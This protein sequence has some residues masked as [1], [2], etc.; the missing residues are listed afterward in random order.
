MDTWGIGICVSASQKGLESP[1]GLSLVAIGKSG[2]ERIEQVKCA[3]WYLNP[4]VWKEY[5]KKWDNWH[6]HPITHAVNNVRA[7]RVGAERILNEGLEARFQRHRNITRK[8]R[9]GLRE[10]GF[11]LYVPG[12]FASHGVTAVV[13]PEGK[14]DELLARLRSQ[15]G[16][17][18]AGSLGKL[19]GK[20]FRIGHMG[21]G[22]TAEAVA[23]VLSALG[24]ALAAVR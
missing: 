14:V 17:L 6:P 24:K 23:T 7:L 2:W 3:G 5:E 13:G 20:V 11:E 19:K 12:E 1:P 9:Q 21:P 10:L 22:A 18:L 15:Y 8:L 4:K 16:L